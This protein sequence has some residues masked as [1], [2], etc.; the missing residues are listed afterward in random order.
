M[1]IDMVSSMMAQENLSISYWEDALLIATYVLNRVP[2]KTVA[3]TPYKLWNN[4]KFDLSNL[5]P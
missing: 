5:Q 4:Q 3:S 2:S 1:L